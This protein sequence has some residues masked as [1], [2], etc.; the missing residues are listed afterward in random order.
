MA[1]N[2][3]SAL[4]AGS[5]IDIT[6][7]VSQLVAAERAPQQALIDTRETTYKAQISGYGKLASALDE[8]DTAMSSLGDADL[9]DARSVTV[10]T[11]DAIT[12]DSV[13]PGA[14]TGTYKI[15]VTAIASS[16]SLATK[17][18]SSRDSALGKSG[19]MTIGFGTWNYGSTPTL[20]ANTERDALSIEVESTDSLDSIAEKINDQD[21]GVQASVVKVGSSY[22]LMLTAPSGEANAMEVSI[23]SDAVGLGDF[24]FHGTS[25]ASVTET[26]QGQDAKLKINGLEVSRESNSID[27]LITGFAFT[28]NTVTTSSLTFSIAADTSSAE[29]AIRDFVT[30]YNTFQETVSDLVGYSRDE[31]NNLVKGDLASDSTAR[32]MISQLRQSV[33][34]AVPGVSGSFNSLANIG[35][36]TELDGSLSIDDDQL[37]NAISDNFDQVAGLFSAK[38]STTNTAVTLKQGTFASKAVAGTYDVK[39]TQDPTQG[40]LVGNAV[41]AAPSTSSPLDTSASGTDYSFMLDVNGV[42]SGT[43]ELTGTYDSTEALRSALQSAIN[44]DAT[45]KANDALVDV[46]YDSS[47]NAFSI[48]S[49]EYGSV[50]NVSITQAGAN[51]SELG[52]TQKTG[53]AGVDVVGTINGVAGFGA[54]NVLLPA[55]DSDAYGLNFT[56]AAGASAQGSFTATYSRGF[57]GELAKLIDAFTGTSGTIASREESI[58]SQLDGLDE[59]TTKLDSRMEKISARL[60]AQFIVMENIVDSLNST[61]SQLEGLVDR[62]PFTSSS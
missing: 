58:Q 2:I 48:V 23:S 11:S 1:N 24:E 55:L 34:G 52:L 44:S 20:T 53:T 25:T 62:L 38:L 7:L 6:S 9:F 28:L 40:L 54:G 61:S 10:P 41:T 12:A 5:G 51:M 32:A 4:G 45:L 56:V 19:T 31:D 49:R 59:E 46:L 17:A 13:S 60:T 57:G 33:V 22:Q 15:D 26:Q 50:S 30:A 39:I 14:Q 35:I 8:L 21:A 47:A 27:D 16:Q 43:I 18:Q 42:S 37:T 3:I 29:T 36:F